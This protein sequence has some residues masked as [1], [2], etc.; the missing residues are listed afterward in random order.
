ME[1]KEQNNSVTLNGSGVLSQTL[2]CGIPHSS[3]EITLKEQKLQVENMVLSGK[4]K[5]NDFSQ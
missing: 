4:G 3:L 1:T 5:N 2:Q